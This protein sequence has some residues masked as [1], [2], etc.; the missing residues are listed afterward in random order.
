LL[1]AGKLAGGAK[2]LKMD[3]DAKD[4]PRGVTGY[5]LIMSPSDAMVVLIRARVAAT[6]ARTTP[7]RR[8]M[9]DPSVWLGAGEVWGIKCNWINALRHHGL[10]LWGTFDFFNDR[11]SKNSNGL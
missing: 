5:F 1:S 9:K 11:F 2:Q 8:T 6:A 7:A 10:S 3:S 4:Q